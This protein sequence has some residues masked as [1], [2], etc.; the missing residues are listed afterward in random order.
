MRPLTG[1]EQSQ[2]DRRRARFDAFLD[3]SMPVLTDFM[4]RLDLPN[5]PLVL[6][7]AEKYL[8]AIDLW[9]RDQVVD[10]S[11]R[12]WILTRSGYFIGEYLVQRQGGYWFLN[13]APDSRYFGRYVVGHFSRASHPSA[14]VDPFG[15]ASE[16]VNEPPGR[17]LSAILDQVED[18]IRQA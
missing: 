5:P 6:V 3:E 2:I 11:G 9:M 18:E 15:V 12:V 8:P 13:D 1:E 17:S 4:Q 16:Y 7:E 10:D 14:M